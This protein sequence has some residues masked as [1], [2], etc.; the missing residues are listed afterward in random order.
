MPT[1]EY[2]AAEGEKGCPTC[3]CGFEVMHG[4]NEPSPAVCPRCGS[5]VVRRISAPGLAL[6]WNEKATLSDANI[7]RHGFKQVRNEGDGKF[8]VT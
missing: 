2:E 6:R 8:R 5:K 4:M 7:K 1:Y 3:H